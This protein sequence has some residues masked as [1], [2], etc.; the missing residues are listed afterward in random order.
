MNRVNK[1]ILQDIVHGKT[2][3]SCSNIIN[4]V[5]TRIENKSLNFHALMRNTKAS[6]DFGSDHQSPP[7]VTEHEN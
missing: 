7:F 2:Y 6:I 1:Y 3:I 5:S 4:L